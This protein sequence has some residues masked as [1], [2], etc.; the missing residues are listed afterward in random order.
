MALVVLKDV[1]LLQTAKCPSSLVVRQFYRM[2][3]NFLIFALQ[4]NVPVQ[5][6]LH[7][8]SEC[9]T[10]WNSAV[11]FGQF[12]LFQEQLFAP[13]VVPHLEYFLLYSSWICDST[14]CITMWITVGNCTGVGSLRGIILLGKKESHNTSS[15][16]AGNLSI[17]SIRGINPRS[18]SSSLL[19]SD[20][21]DG[22]T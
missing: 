12:F 7:S 16:T 19:L 6:C 1:I 4:Y 22:G 21:F 10:S 11:I 17:L 8:R 20:A 14:H 5:I 3:H 13:T 15:R 2:T 18:D 9:A